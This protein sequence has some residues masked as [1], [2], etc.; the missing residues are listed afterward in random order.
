M[1][2]LIQRISGYPQFKVAKEHLITVLVGFSYS[3]DQK[4]CLWIQNSYFR[5]KLVFINCTS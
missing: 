1:N 5:F 4:V 3:Y 2:A